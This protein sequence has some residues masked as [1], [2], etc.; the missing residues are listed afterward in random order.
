M[1]GTLKRISFLVMLLSGIASIFIT[2][3]T[4]NGRLPGGLTLANKPWTIAV[5]VFGA[6]VVVSVLLKIFGPAFE[7]TRALH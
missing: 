4:L 3:G 5:S 6:A 7:D 2:L 1:F